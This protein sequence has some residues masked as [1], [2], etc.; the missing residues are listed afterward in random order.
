MCPS[1]WMI[2]KPPP[3]PCLSLSAP[4]SPRC[5]PHILLKC[6][7]SSLF[8]GIVWNLGTG[9]PRKVGRSCAIVLETQGREGWIFLLPALGRRAEPPMAG[10]HLKE[11]GTHRRGTPHYLPAPYTARS[12]VYLRL[13]S[14]AYH[15]RC[16]MGS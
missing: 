2:S 16:E 15:M 5:C 8:S 11:C 1:G 9:S 10:R 7:L 6:F 12:T 13:V 14:T 3:T 4:S